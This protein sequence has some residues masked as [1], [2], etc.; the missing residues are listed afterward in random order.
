MP[1]SCCG[2]ANRPQTLNMSLREKLLLSRGI[3]AVKGSDLY[4][5]LRVF[6]VIPT[7]D[8][9][10]DTPEPAVGAVYPGIH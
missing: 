4:G 5:L 9:N 2:T 3:K 6:G 7:T 1:R 10:R 8:K